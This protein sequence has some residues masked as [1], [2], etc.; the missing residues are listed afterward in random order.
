MPA[1]SMPAVVTDPLVTLVPAVRPEVRMPPTSLVIV[2]LFTATPVGTSVL[3]C[4][5]TE[6]CAS[7]A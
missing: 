3:P 4:A 5:G 1:T 2:P 6:T 7:S